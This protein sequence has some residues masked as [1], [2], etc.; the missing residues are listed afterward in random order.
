MR[1]YNLSPRELKA[2]DEFVTDSLAKG[3]IRE[4]TSPAGAPELFAPKK[5]RTLRLYVDYRGL[6]AVTIKNRYPL[7]LISE[8]LDR[9][10]GAKV[11]SKIDLKDAYYRIRIKK[12]DEWKTAFRTRY[13]H[14]EFLVMPIG[15]T[16]APATF[17]S[18]INQ[19]LRGYVDDFCVVYLDDILV[20]SR[21][22][23]EHYQHLD[24]IMDCLPS[25]EKATAS[26]NSVSPSSVWSKASHSGCTSGILRIQ[27]ISTRNFCLTMLLWGA[28]MRA[29]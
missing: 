16:N 9:L 26:T 20:F 21:T 10:N 4:S 13:G 12:G 1:T 15:L 18:Y 27:G 2:L 24:L 7:S 17:Q 19:A 8:L 14:F 5:D 11:F 29:E 6:N 22:E 28:K 23:E 25:G 3:Y